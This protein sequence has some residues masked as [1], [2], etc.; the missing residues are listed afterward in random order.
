LEDD[1]NIKPDF[2][3]HSVVSQAWDDAFL[4]RLFR[5]V[6]SLHRV[7]HRFSCI[8]ISALLGEK[9]WGARKPRVTSV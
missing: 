1:K 5:V 2:F 4:E 9:D 6:A 7:L 3:S 8:L